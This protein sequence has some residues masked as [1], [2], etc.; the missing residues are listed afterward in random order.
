MT[1]KNSPN[2]FLRVDA[3]RCPFASSLPAAFQIGG[4]H[5]RRLQQLAA[6]AVQGDLA[7]DQHVAAVGEPQRLKGVLLDQEDG[8]PL[9]RC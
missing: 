5:L 1:S 6:G 9:A 8:E 2:D 4:A 3:M 7:V